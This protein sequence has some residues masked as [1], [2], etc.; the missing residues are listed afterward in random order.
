MGQAIEPIVVRSWF[1]RLTM[2]GIAPL[3][4]S[5]SKG[6]RPLSP[7]KGLNA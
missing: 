1:D 7:R 5:L 6:E 2:S 3:V 4:L